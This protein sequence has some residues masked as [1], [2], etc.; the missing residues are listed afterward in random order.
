MQKLDKNEILSSVKDLQK[1]KVWYVSIIWRPNVWKSTFL[2]SLIWEK[3]SIVSNIPQT[4]RKKVLWIYN[5]EDSQIIFLDTPWI[6]KNEKSFNQAIN[7]EALKTLSKA[8]VILYFIDSTRKWWEEEDFIKEAISTV[9]TPVMKIYTKSDLSSEI[10]VPESWFY[11]SSIN[12]S[13]FDDVLSQIK[14]YLKEDFALFPEEY[15]TDSWVFFRISEIIREKVFLNTKEEIPH[16]S[17]VEVEEYED[18]WHLLKVAANIYVESDSQKYIVVWKSWALITKIWKEARLELEWLYW[19][20][21]F[22]ALKVKKL[23]KW[24]KKGN[25]IKRIF[26]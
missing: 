4:T 9:N 16:S 21:V 15:Y 6:H 1:K 19:K 7:S 24:R 8:D 12:K 25:I 17:F 10:N 20:K 3:V 2:N 5:D 23:D 26:S 11:I 18:K 14:I 22:L 13:W